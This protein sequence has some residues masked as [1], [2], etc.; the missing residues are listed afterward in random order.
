M[1]HA[2][3]EKKIVASFRQLGGQQEDCLTVLYS[4][5]FWAI[6]YN[7]SICNVCMVSWRAEYEVHAVARGRWQDGS[8]SRL[9]KNKVALKRGKRQAIVIFGGVWMGSWL[10]LQS[11]L[12][13]VDDMLL[14]QLF[15]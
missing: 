9:V 5:F 15:G 2:R 10:H 3:K 13:M 12:L 7:I 11:S 6:Q 8:K 4:V 1:V 14:I